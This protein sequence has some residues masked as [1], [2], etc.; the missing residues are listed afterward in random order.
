VR[1][2]LRDARP[3][4]LVDQYPRLD[5]GG[6]PSCGVQQRLVDQQLVGADPGRLSWRR[7]RGQ[8]VQTALQAVAMVSGQDRQ[9]AIVR[10]GAIRSA[11]GGL[12]NRAI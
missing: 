4:L 9:D 7:R 6:K 8:A 11:G 3:V 10:P 12:G 5:L 2:Q 1:R